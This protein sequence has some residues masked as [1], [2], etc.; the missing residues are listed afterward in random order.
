MAIN[1]FVLR[2]GWN[3]PPVHAGMMPGIILSFGQYWRDQRR[4]V[5][6]QLRDFGFGTNNMEGAIAEEVEKLVGQYEKTAGTPVVM[7][8]KISVVNSLWQILVGEKLE[9]DDPKL[10]DIVDTISTFAQK[11]SNPQNPI[12]EMLPHPALVKLPILRDL[13]GLEIAK[14]T[15]EKV[16]SMISKYIKEHQVGEMKAD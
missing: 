8:S 15:F 14:E 6:R 11:A 2:I 13:A 4:F 12:G 3:D 9:L 1:L 5:L 16:A 10:L 7:D